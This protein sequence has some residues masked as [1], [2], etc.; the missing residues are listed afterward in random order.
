MGNSKSTHNKS[1]YVIAGM[2]VLLFLSSIMLYYFN[3]F[4]S[5]DLYLGVTAFHIF[6]GLA[7]FLLLGFYLII[8][9]RIKQDIMAKRQSLI[10]LV[11][12]ILVLTCII[13]GLALTF[14]DIDNNQQWIRVVHPITAILSLLSFQLHNSFRNTYYK[15]S[16]R[17]TSSIL[18]HPFYATMIIGLLLLVLFALPNLN[19]REQNKDNMGNEPLLAPGEA[20]LA[21]HQFL[22]SAMLAGSEDCGIPGCHPD[23]YDQWNE[24]MHHFSSFNNPYYSKSIEVLRSTGNHTSVRWCASCHDPLPLMTG[25]MKDDLEDFDTRHPLSL[26]G[27]TCLSCHAIKKTPDIKGNGKYEMEQVASFNKLGGPMAA[28]LHKGLLKSNPEPHIR[29]MLKPMQ[30]TAEFCVSCHKVSI[31]PQINGYRWKRGQDQYDSWQRSGVSGNNIRA[32]YFPE[33]T[34]NC[35]NCHMPD[36]PSKDKGNKNGFVKSHRFAGANTAVPHINGHSNQLNAVRANL[37]NDIVEMDMMRVKVNNRVFDPSQHLSEMK[38]GD[39]VDITLIINN[40]KVGHRMPAGTNDTNEWWLEV[41]ALNENGEAILASGFTDE[42]GRVD[43]SAHFLRTVLIDKNGNIIDKRNANDIYATAYNNTIA[44]GTAQ[45][46]RFRFKVPDG[47][48]INSIKASLKQRKFNWY[49]NNLT[50]NGVLEDTLTEDQVSSIKKWVIINVSKPEIPITT[51]ASTERSADKKYSRP[52]PIWKRW[53]DY[54]IGLFLEGNN[55]EAY[56][57]FGHVEKINPQSADGVINMARVL[58]NEGSVYEAI[59]LINENIDRFP[60]NQR[61]DFFLGKAYELQGEY[62]KAIKYWMKIYNSSKTD[63]KLL[64]DISNAFYLQGEYNRAT[65][66][67]SQ[68]LAIDPEDFGAIYQQMLIFQAQGKVE[69]AEQW[70]KKYQYYKINEKEEFAVADFLEAN[71]QINIETHDTHYHYLEPI[72]TMNNKSLLAKR[73]QR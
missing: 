16:K 47:I 35:I 26:A 54:G 66:F 62:K 57:A 25:K 64:L 73:Q 19:F 67:T 48:T 23:I 32:F 65:D 40:R 4:T 29:S 63:F 6:V 39:E 44:P 43:S 13:S 70:K 45:L 37:M 36:V 61:L 20:V 9:L 55:K 46:V 2:T 12:L 69:L 24:S 5:S 51:I 3:H 1:F 34:K 7:V 59:E 50:F 52:F 27:I 41:M 22:D 53:N 14:F 38:E 56:K 71:P 11:T 31:P 33:K 10:G 17:M 8:H 30:S 72:K 15:L 21:D 28:N 49:Y 58:V 18:A 42:M 60:G 68:A